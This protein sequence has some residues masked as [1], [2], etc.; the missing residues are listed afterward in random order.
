M[1]GVIAKLLAKLQS[2]GTVF[3]SPTLNT[4]TLNTPTT[5]GAA[6]FNGTAAHKGIVEQVIGAIATQAIQRA[7]R[8][9]TGF[10]RWKE[11]LEADAGYAL[12]NYDANGANSFR[13]VY[14]PPN[15]SAAPAIFGNPLQVQSYLTALG[16]ATIGYQNGGSGGVFV[17]TAAHYG[18]PA[19]QAVTGAFGTDTLALNPVGG[20]VV[21]GGV[22]ANKTAAK[23]R[24]AAQADH[25]ARAVTGIVPLAEQLSWPV[26]E[27][28]ARAHQAGTA[29]AGQTALLAAEAGVTGET[30][31]ALVEKILANAVAYHM[32]AGF[33]A[34]WRRKTMEAI[35]VLAD[36]ATVGAGIATIVAQAAMEAE[37]ALAA[38]G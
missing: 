12:Y 24:L 33:I 9:S 27:A 23:E 29:D 8:W 14:L 5:N 10:E 6:T 4:P 19:V 34:G 11:V 7:L 30:V 36:D 15:G 16:N 32:A 18:K 35:D 20:G 3:N 13:S 28:A 38:L 22:N 26:K 37:A 1:E 31:G 2:A 25:M 17:T 21:I